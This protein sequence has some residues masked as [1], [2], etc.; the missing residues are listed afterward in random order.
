[1][2]ECSHWIE[3]DA[4]QNVPV[5]IYMHGN[6][7]CR[8][9]VLPQLSYLLV[10]GVSVLSFDFAGSGWSEGEYVS[11]GYYER[12]DLTCVIA[13]LRAQHITNIAL[14]GRSMGAATALMYNDRDPDIGCMILDSSFSDLVQLAEE[15][16]AKAREQG[17]LV[18]GVVVS[19]ALK[20]IQWSVHHHAKFNINDISP[21]KHAKDCKSPALFVV[22]EQDDFI[23]NHHS[24][25]ICEVYAGSKSL[26]VVHG[27]H[28]EPRPQ[29]MFDSASLFLK[30][31]LKVPGDWELPVHPSMNLLHPPWYH[32]SWNPP[33]KS[34]RTKLSAFAD[35]TDE[36][37]VPPED[38]PSKDDTG[39][40]N[41]EMGMTEE[42]QK[43]IQHSLFKMLGHEE[44]G[45]E[46]SKRAVAAEMSG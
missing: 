42:R 9:E 17:I 1:M 22:G 3:V 41:D 8:L 43:E 28:N 27:D 13:H 11:L 31:H 14:W 35:K 2:I 32:K 45:G 34:N 24:E 38:V 29:V 26:L 23:Q 36:H 21:I 7:S 37:D 16:V 33:P 44:E 12:E 6:A 46:K 30:K 10:L 4:A 40:D 5:L 39:F 18:P 25:K 15:M 20:A 19:V